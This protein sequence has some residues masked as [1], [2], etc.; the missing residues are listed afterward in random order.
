VGEAPQE[1]YGTGF[2]ATIFP[3]NP[4]ATLVALFGIGTNIHQDMLDLPRV[5]PK[6]L[7]YFGTHLF[8]VSGC[9]AT[10]A[11][12]SEACEGS[13]SYSKTLIG[14]E[15]VQRLVS[16]HYSLVVRTPSFAMNTGRLR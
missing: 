10:G 12:E 4:T 16:P 8:G 14:G 11:T 9:G 1:G 6:G 5:N 13:E 2:E 15:Y 3:E 7:T